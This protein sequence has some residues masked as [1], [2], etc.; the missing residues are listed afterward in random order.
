MYTQFFTKINNN[1]GDITMNFKTPNDVIDYYGKTNIIA[2]INL[3]QILT[4]A[5]WNVQPKFIYESEFDKKLVAY[6]LQSETTEVWKRWLSNK[7]QK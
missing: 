3:R 2:L 7:P 1:N 5:N 6:Y 4:Y